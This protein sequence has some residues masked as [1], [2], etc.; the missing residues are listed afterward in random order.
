M[1]KIILFVIFSLITLNIYSQNEA[2]N[3]YFG[4]DA[5][6]SFNIFTGGVTPIGDGEINTREGCASISDSNGDLLFY[7]DGTTVYN[8]NH[9]IMDNGN[10]LLGDESSTQSAI[11]VPKPNDPNTYYI[12]TVGSNQ[13]NTGLNYSEVDITAD[14]NNGSVIKKNTNLLSQCAEKISAVVKDCNTKSIWVITLA[15]SSGFG[16]TN[17][18]TFFAYEVNDIGVVATPIKSTFPISIQDPRGYLK[19]SPNGSKLACANIQSGLYLFDFDSDT[20]IVS[21]S[22]II[23]INDPSNKPYGIEFSSNSELLF[24]TSTNDFFNRTDSSQNDNPSNHDSLLLQFNL[25]ATDI[26][27]SMFVLDRR[28]LYRG[29]LQL[30]P[31]GKIYRAL[32]QTYNIGYKGLGVINKPNEIG[33][34]SSYEHNAI[35]LPNNSTQ[36]LPPFIASFFNQ[37]IDIIKN[38]GETAFLTLCEDESYTL[39]ADNIL[40]ATFTWTL[41]DVLLPES[42]NELLIENITNGGF[43]NGT[44]KVVIDPPGASITKDCGLPQGEA[45][46]EF[47]EYP[48]ANNASLFQCDFDLSSINITTFNLTEANEI[49]TD[50]ITGL[51]ITYYNT[52]NEAIDDLNAIDNIENY[53]NTVQGELL[54]TRVTHDIS[55]CFET[56]ELTLNVSN[57]QVDKYFATSLCDEQDSPDGINLFQLK[58][59]SAEIILNLGLPLSDTRVTFYTSVNDALTENNEILEFTN[60]IPYSETIYYRVETINNNECYGIN[61]IELTVDKLPDLEEDETIFYCLNLFPSTI[62]IEAGIIDGI[63]SDYTYLWSTGEVTSEIS[64][65]AIGT[66][67]VTATNAND[68]SNTRTITVEASNEATFDKKAEVIDIRENNTI[69]VF[70]SGEGTYQYSLVNNLSVTIAPYQDSNVFENVYPGIYN[71]LVKDIKNNCGTVNELV[72]VIGFPKYFTPNNDGVNDTWQILGT[73]E[74]FQPNS[75]IYIYDR[76]GKLLK[77]ISP[78]EKGWDGTLN[79]KTLPADDYW[80]SVKLEDG[81]I[82]KNHFSLVN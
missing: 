44:Y 56:S 75:K 57:T 77:Q 16:N 28:N 39:T 82:Y 80:F 46:V 68:C 52:P 67:I 50:D 18:D 24:V 3:W 42:S 23:T 29:G 32:S 79:G 21:N 17:F 34:A 58:P 26:S 38:G 33:A 63:I 13:T 61:E 47:F 51:T 2:S 43:G 11:V 27:G 22:Q 70:V 53:E 19:L 15:T 62:S 41:N 76:F 48:T 4:E 55:G 72:S 69:T 14:S 6:I 36:G 40:G 71:V 81:R 49:I 7:T 78:L 64:I 45:I 35:S 10:D 60:T 30:G 65:N 59:Y 1:K 12:F 8:R 66:Y 20:G 74:M 37:Q 54:Y 25:N 5:G 31:N 9:D 73:S